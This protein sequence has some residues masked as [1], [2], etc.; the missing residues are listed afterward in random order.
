MR[1][2]TERCLEAARAPSTRLAYNAAWLAFVEYQGRTLARYLPASERDV[3][4][5]LAELGE[6]RA[7]A[8]VRL[9]AA[10]IAAAHRDAGHPSPTE[11]AH[12][13]RILAGNGNLHRAGDQGQARPLDAEAF[14]AVTEHAMTPRRTRGG[15]VETEAEAQSRA[16]LDVALIGLMRD[17]LLRRAEAAAL[18][19]ADF[20]L[21]NDASGTVRIRRSKTD[22][23]GKGYT[24]YVSPEVCEVLDVLRTVRQAGPHDPI[25]GLSPSQICRRI[26]A[27]CEAAGLGSGFSGHSPRVGMAVD[28]ARAGMSMPMIMVAGGWTSERTVKRY[29]EAVTANRGAVAAWYR[30]QEEA[31][32]PTQH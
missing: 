16:L 4:A 27:A 29:V 18:T 1:D 15:R 32:D 8:T 6:T 19:W 21:E 20:T 2:A 11:T 13:R 22:Q 26:Q 23:T 17:A 24:R 12:V 9:H 28:I 25:I 14:D 7:P 3:G 10:A 5:Y 30:Q 31:D